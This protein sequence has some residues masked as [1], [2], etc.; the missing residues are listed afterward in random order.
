MDLFEELA[1]SRPSQGRAIQVLGGGEALGGV[2]ERAAAAG[3]Y[4]Q[5][6][7]VA[8]RV[9]TLHPRQVR[10]SARLNSWLH[11]PRGQMGLRQRRFGHSCCR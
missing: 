11:T 7:R 10:A 9:K 1:C 4:L 5:Q 2:Q 8:E 3:G 6:R